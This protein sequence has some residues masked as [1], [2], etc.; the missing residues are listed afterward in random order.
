MTFFAS[1]RMA[2][3][4]NRFR[5][6]TQR[7]NA[8]ARGLLGWTNWVFVTFVSHLCRIVEILDQ[9]FTSPVASTLPTCRH[10]LTRRMKCKSLF[11]PWVY[12]SE[13]R[14]RSPAGNCLQIGAAGIR[15]RSPCRI[16]Y[17]RRRKRVGSGTKV[18]FTSSCE[19][20]LSQLD[21]FDLKPH[22][23]REIRGDFEPIQTVIPGLQILSACRCSRRLP[24][25]SALSVLW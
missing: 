2:K 16:C 24:T 7:S 22:A 11:R 20:V 18:S 8:T 9:G 5:G 17:G 4:R 21:T 14:R 6:R 3:I 13:H 12:P 23:P 15:R 10:L 25:N 19:V 1:A